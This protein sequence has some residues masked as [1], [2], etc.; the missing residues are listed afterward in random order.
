MMAIDK[1]NNFS[2]L[3]L[4]RISWKHLKCVIKDDKYLS[5]IVN[6]TNACI[7]LEYWLSYFKVSLSIIIPKP[8]KVVYN[9]PKSFCPIIFLN[10]IGKLIEKAISKWLQYH[11]IANNFIYPNQLGGLKQWSTMDVGLFLTYLICSGWV[12]NL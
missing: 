10:M 9:S 12:K 11:L 2:T 4:D 7:N 1:C 6:I 8:N 5:N 3:K